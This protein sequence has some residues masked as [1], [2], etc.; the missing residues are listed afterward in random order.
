MKK[1]SRVVFA[2]DGGFA[3]A[4]DGKVYSQGGFPAANWGRYLEFS[5]ELIV[6]ARMNEAESVSGVVSSRERVSF[7]K[8][9]SISTPTQ[10]VTNRPLARA[11]LENEIRS[12]DHLIVRLPSEI[13]LLAIKVARKLEKKFSIELVGDPLTALFHHKKFYAKLYAPVLSLR[14]KRAVSTSRACIYV[15]RKTLQN[16]YPCAGLS[17]SASNVNITLSPWE[18]LQK[19]LQ[20]KATTPRKS[21]SL[22]GTM[23]TNYKGIDIAIKA[24][25]LLIRKGHDCDLRILGSGDNSRYLELSRTLGVSGNVHFDGARNSPK[26]VLEWLDLQTFYIQPSR[27]EGLPRSLIEAMS[28]GL[29]SAGSDRGGIPELLPAEQTFR[30]LDHTELSSIMERMLN[31]APHEYLSA[32]RRSYDTASTYEKARLDEIRHDFWNKSLIS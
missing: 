1:L 21:F 10:A 16:L 4:P 20:A 9:P 19:I 18:E 28:R 5:E 13:G 3:K 29:P 14:I 12:A 15:T 7:V 31:F 26:E 8:V 2:Y 22:V 17:A 23:A 6:T 11:I 27:S 30:N 25:S 32:C 24:L